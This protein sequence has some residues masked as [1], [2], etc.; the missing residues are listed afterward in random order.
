MRTARGGRPRRRR[1]RR[2]SPASGARRSGRSTARP[3]WTSEDSAREHRFSDPRDRHPEVERG[4]HGPGAGALGTGRVED[5]VDQRLP[6]DGVVL[7]Q[8]LG[9]DLDQVGVQLAGVPLG[10]DVGDLDRALAG[11]LPDQVVGLGDQLHVGVLDA[12]V[13]HLDEVACTIGAHV[14]HARLALG[15]RGDRRQDRPQCLPRL[16]AAARHDR[17]AVERALLTA[18]DA[19]ADEVDAALARRL[20]AADGVGEERV[21]AVDDDVAG[22]EHLDQLVD[23]GVGAQPALTM[24]IAVRGLASESAS[25]ST[26][27]ASRTPPRGAPRGARGLRRRAV[28]DRDGVALAAREVPGEVRPHHGETDDGDVG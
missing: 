6:G 19:G 11:A 10:E 25:S 4:L 14:R 17:R 3:R 22:L 26:V 7:P 21:A 2:R 12:V 9:G 16:D 24:M 18:R 28:V 23:D 27:A 15:D 5:D 1:R 8:H 20:L 13:D